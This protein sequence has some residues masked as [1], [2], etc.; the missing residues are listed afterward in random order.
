[1]AAPRAFGERFGPGFGGPINVGTLVLKVST[2][3]PDPAYQDGDILCAF[4]RRRTRHVHAEG[5][6]HP[7]RAQRRSDGRIAL[8]HVSRAWFEATHQ[9]RF[10]RL[11]LTAVLRENLWMPSEVEVFGQTPNER[12]ERIDV[13]AYVR[14]RA[15]AQ[16]FGLFGSDGA[17]I[18][19]G[20]STRADTPTLDTVW[21]AIEQHTPHREV[22]Y[23][24]WPIGA[25]E[26]RSHLVIR[27]DD[28]D[29]EEA[30]ALTAPVHDT[31]GEEPVLVRK[32]ARRLPWRDLHGMSAAR[33]AQVEDRLTAVDIRAERKHVRAVSVRLK[34]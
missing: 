23:P 8:D 11:S 10:T 12:G 4:N 31:S 3:G 20:G 2:V 29:D 1:M 34:D 16:G 9:Y 21:G 19:Y 33:I 30:E 5:I 18:W 13:D 28:F 27:V 6:C 7:R 15:Q 26:L 22:D 32:R 25:Q 17:E 14:R 24:D